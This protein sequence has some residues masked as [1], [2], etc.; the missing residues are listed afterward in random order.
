MS[1]WKLSESSVFLNIWEA[2]VCICV[3]DWPEISALVPQGLVPRKQKRKA[4]A[5]S[6]METAL[7]SSAERM[8]YVHG[9]GTE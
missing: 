6:R 1:G 8:T 7:T 4:L 2:Y 5:S 3:R 9:K